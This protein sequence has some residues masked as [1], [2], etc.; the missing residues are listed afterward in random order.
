MAEQHDEFLR[1]L[2]VN[3]DE[4]RRAAG[5]VGSS[6]SNPS[7]NDPGLQ[8]ALADTVT[9]FG[10]GF[11]KGVVDQSS[12]IIN[13]PGGAIATSMTSP[14]AF[15]TRVI[16]A[17]ATGDAN[18]LAPNIGAPPPIDPSDPNQLKQAQGQVAFAQGFAGQQFDPLGSAL[19]AASA[20]ADV[21]VNG[22][23]NQVGQGAGRTFVLTGAALAGGAGEAAAAEAGAAEA[24]AGGA[25]AE[26]SA[27][28]E[29][30]AAGAAPE[31][32]PG[33]SSVPVPEGAVA[34]PGPISALD[35]AFADVPPPAASGVPDAVV[36][37]GADG[38]APTQQAPQFGGANPVVDFGADG[39]APTQQAPQFGG[40]EISPAAVSTP[41]PP[42]FSPAAE[43][44]PIPQTADAV[45]VPEPVIEDG[46]T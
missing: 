11:G 41:D 35:P 3:L 20:S 16:T 31:I 46:A 19:G 12:E 22:D 32:S 4:L 40:S 1:N 23:P 26:G 43:S 6:G 34:P 18:A 27:A 38:G 7:I 17:I 5:G 33:A 37:F 2:G 44:V 25:A 29:S 39:G 42:V 28:A 15:P 10:K 9:E 30:G 45:S 24:G 8:T 36:D 14:L 21:L 13:S